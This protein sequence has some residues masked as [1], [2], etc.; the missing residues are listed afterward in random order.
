MKKISEF[1]SKFSKLR[2][3][4][5]ITTKECIN[6]LKRNNI[7]LDKTAISVRNN[8]IYITANAVIKTEIFTQKEKILSELNMVLGDIMVKDIR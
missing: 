6:I 7:I 4:N 1:F 8:T 2:P 3:S 5:Q